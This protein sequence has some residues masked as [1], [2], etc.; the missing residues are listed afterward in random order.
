MKKITIELPTLYADHHVVEV[1][2]ILLEM[3]GIEDVYAS[4]AF[5]MVEVTY[6]PARL[7]DLEIEIK[8]D[9][10]GYMGE[11]TLPM[12]TGVSTANQESQ[13]AFSRHTEVFENNRRVVSF[14]Q[15]VDGGTAHSGRPLWN[16]PGM[17]V[18]VTKNL[19][20]KMEE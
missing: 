7:N 3:P 11:W 15:T 12:E 5:H 10:A 13:A 19:I 18:M 14:K 1:K 2:R 8:L 16:C 4:S 17:G 9:E 6:D 20:N